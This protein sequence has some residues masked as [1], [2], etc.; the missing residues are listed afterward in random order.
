M[1]QEAGGAVKSSI[2]LAGMAFSTLGRS[3]REKYNSDAMASLFVIAYNG[4]EFVLETQLN[5]HIFH[6]NCQFFPL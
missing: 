2:E 6:C 1:S 3:E 4:N 5:K